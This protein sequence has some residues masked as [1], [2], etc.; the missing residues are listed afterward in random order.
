M[1]HIQVQNWKG[2]KVLVMPFSKMHTRVTHSHKQRNNL[3]FKLSVLNSDDDQVRET[4]R[5]SLALHVQKKKKKKKK[6]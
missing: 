3:F 2:K 5:S 4:A 6:C 1:T